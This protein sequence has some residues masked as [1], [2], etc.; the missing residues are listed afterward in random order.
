LF[1]KA[2]T[3]GFSPEQSRSIKFHRRVRDTQGH[4]AEDLDSVEAVAEA[5]V[6]ALDAVDDA[7]EEEAGGNSNSQR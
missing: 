3:S 6:E 2:V 1:L 4:L 7:Q 5:K